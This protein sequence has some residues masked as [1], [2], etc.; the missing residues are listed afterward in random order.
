MTSLEIPD[1]TACWS[2]G[3]RLLKNVVIG[4]GLTYFRDFSFRNCSSLETLAIPDSVT[5]IG[6]FVFW[7]CTALKTLAFGTGVRGIIGHNSF[8]GCVNLENF[9]VPGGNTYYADV[10]GVLF[11]KDKRMLFFFP[12][13]RGGT[14]EIPDGT[15]DVY[16]EA[17]AGCD[18]LEALRIPA[19]VVDGDEGEWAGNNGISLADCAGLAGI[20]VDGDNPVYA[21]VDGVIFSKDKRT[22]LC[23]PRAREGAYEIPEGV[24]DIDVRQGFGD[25][26]RLT[27]VR[28]PASVTNLWDSAF[29][30]CTNL[31]EISVSEDNPLYASEDGVLFDRNKRRL[32]RCPPGKTGTYAIPEGVTEVAGGGFGNCGKLTS[33]QI[34]ASVTN[35]H[36]A[37]QWEGLE[38]LRSIEVATENPCYASLD[39][40]LFDKGMREI[41]CFPQGWEG[42]YEVPEGVESLE[43]GAFGK[44]GTLTAVKIPASVTNIE[45][46]AFYGCRMLESIET[47]AGNAVYESVGGVLFGKGGKTLV[48]YPPGKTGV[49]EIPWAVTNL[50]PGCFEECAGLKELSI[51]GSIGARKGIEFGGTGLETL[52]IPAVWFGTNRWDWPGWWHLPDACEVVFAEG[53]TTNTPVPVPHG[54]LEAN[55]PGILA[56][57][58]RNY[59]AAAKAAAANWMPVWKCYLAGLSATDPEAAFTAEIAFTNGEARIS[60]DPDLGDGRTYTVE[61]AAQLGGEDAWGG[62][63]ADSRYFR[64]KVGLAE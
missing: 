44:C 47:A 25:C 35:V 8:D 43:F 24:M 10:D 52:R 37:F 55:V 29:S 14:Y 27:S 64:V 53:A 21:S 19:S 54:W 42:K 48:R 28:I 33:V 59:E 34:P 26:A 32:I 15:T 17:F 50:A 38:R 18:K 12:R 2:C 22:L 30:R 23:Y 62:V 46:G 51:P 11:S 60:W 6:D 4:E 16:W 45:E 39:G 49:L 9:T 5:G 57:S 61:G 1:G 31:A 13:G 63:T 20:E 58:G 3:G 7:G 56:A 36:G 40:V 41:S